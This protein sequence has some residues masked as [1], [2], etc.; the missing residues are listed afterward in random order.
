MRVLAR[1]GVS[2]AGPYVIALE[3]MDALVRNAGR[4][5]IG[6]YRKTNDLTTL[7]SLIGFAQAQR[8]ALESLTQDLPPAAR[9]AARSSIDL[10]IVLQNRVT[11]VLRGCPCPADILTPPATTGGAP[12]GVACTC[13]AKPSVPKTATPPKTSAPPKTSPPKTTPPKVTD[14]VT[15]LLPDVG[16]TDLDETIEEI[17][18]PFLETLGISPSPDSSSSPLPVPSLGL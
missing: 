4:I 3:S 17:V 8:A 10:L 16:G 11:S 9:P 15:R 18:K 7:D 6:Q 1:R 12:G 5:L 13:P 14:P 2:R